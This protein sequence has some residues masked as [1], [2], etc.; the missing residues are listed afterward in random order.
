LSL[1][2]LYSKENFPLPVVRSEVT[3]PVALLG[4]VVMECLYDYGNNE[5]PSDC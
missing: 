4:G 3:T 1:A 5:R 2:A